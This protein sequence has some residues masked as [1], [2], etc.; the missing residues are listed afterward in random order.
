MEVERDDEPLNLEEGSEPAPYPWHFQTLLHHDRTEI[1]SQVC[2]F[3]F[4]LNSKAFAFYH[5]KVLF[6]IL[7]VVLKNVKVFSKGRYIIYSYNHYLNAI[8]IPLFSLKWYFSIYP[9]AKQLPLFSFLVDFESSDY[10]TFLSFL[11]LW[12]QA[13]NSVNYV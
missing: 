4:Y 11:Q 9:L 6:A 13:G 1:L 3:V 8:F 7:Y 5:N 2:L 12:L 10:R